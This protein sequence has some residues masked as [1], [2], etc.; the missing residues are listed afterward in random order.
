MH[1][2]SIF[3]IKKLAF[4]L[5]LCS[6]LFIDYTFSQN[7]VNINNNQLEKLLNCDNLGGIEKVKCYKKINAIKKCSSLE[8]K[9]KKEKCYLEYINEKSDIKDIYQECAKYKNKLFNLCIKNKE[10]L[11]LDYSEL[12][13]LGIFYNLKNKIAT[14]QNKIASKTIELILNSSKS[15]K[16]NLNKIKNIKETEN[17]IDE[18]KES[19]RK[20][21]LD[22]KI[23]NETINEINNLKT[24]IINSI[25]NL[26][27]LRS[28]N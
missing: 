22:N 10:Q 8:N 18:L 14:T 4:F 17:I 5:F 28:N 26:K 3:S 2:I 21:S 19:V 25:E 12:Y 13:L 7:D 15:A 27:K 16:E 9:D 1:L 20:L 6:F 24:K 11:L 23:K